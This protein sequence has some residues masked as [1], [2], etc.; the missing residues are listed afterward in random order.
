MLVS[1]SFLRSYILLV[2]SESPSRKAEK[3][4]M[5]RGMNEI[6]ILSISATVKKSDPIPIPK[7]PEKKCLFYFVLSKVRL[8]YM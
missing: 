4:T 5:M 2:I 1:P 6:F 3:K 7:N 8:E